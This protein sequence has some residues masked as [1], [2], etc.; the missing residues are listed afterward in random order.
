MAKIK[1]I[2]LIDGSSSQASLSWLETQ[3]G[4]LIKSDSWANNRQ[5]AN[6]ILG[7]LKQ[8][9]DQPGWSWS[10]LTGIGVYAGPGS[11][12]AGRIAHTIA[13]SLG[14]SLQ[15]GLT[16]AAGDNWQQLCY[17]SLAQARPRILKP[18]YGPLKLTGYPGR[19]RPAAGDRS[20]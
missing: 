15:I 6:Q 3:T 10:D 18:V 2:L 20:D 16:Q 19:S 13:N 11:F 14:Y 1:K 12:T 17:A 5:L 8:Q 4:Q 7:R 9:F